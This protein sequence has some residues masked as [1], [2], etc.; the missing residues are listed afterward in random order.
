MFL[1][2]SQGRN[3][4]ETS[5][6]KSLGRQ[7]SYNRVETISSD[8]A[9]GGQHYWNNKRLDLGLQATQVDYLNTEIV[10]GRACPSNEANMFIQVHQCHCQDR[11]PMDT[12]KSQLRSVCLWCKNVSSI[13]SGEWSFTLGLSKLERDS[14]Q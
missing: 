12:Y 11:S 4:S 9:E 8:L 2:L 10:Q 1:Y 3:K 7:T 6:N 14:I 5:F 13:A